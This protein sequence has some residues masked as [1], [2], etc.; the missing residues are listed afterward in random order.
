MKLQYN[1]INFKY[2]KTLIFDNLNLTIENGITVITGNN[3]SGK[4]TLLK[5]T[6]GKLPYDGS[7][8]ID[9]KEIKRYKKY[10]FLDYQYINKL[11]GLVSEYL[12]NID[13]KLIEYM[14]I[15]D[16]LNDD[17]KKLS[18]ETKIKIC[19]AKYINEMDI[20]L[21]DN[22]LCW[23][24]KNDKNKILKR[25]KTIS[26]NKI[27]IITTNNMEDLLFTKRIICLD[28]GKIIIDYDIN[29]FFSDKKR[30]EKYKI[31]LP[32]LIDLSYNLKL[33]NIIDDIYMD[34]GKL[35]DAIWK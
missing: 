3:N 32:F 7:I 5:I 23:L 30:L 13:D 22:L 25:L 16:Y 10:I 14:D 24:N 8:T 17:I 11:K 26:K 33:Y 9:N 34:T 1:N 27:I 12:T 28:K 35:V 29:G 20:L 31:E 4:S 15:I 18:L 6:G 2:D 21:I 19:L